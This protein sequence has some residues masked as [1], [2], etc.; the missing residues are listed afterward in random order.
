MAISSFPSMINESTYTATSSYVNSSGDYVILFHPTTGETLQMP[1]PA[2][3]EE[4]DPEP[5]WE[6]L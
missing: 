6:Q 4:E 2:E 3:P 5:L 1:I